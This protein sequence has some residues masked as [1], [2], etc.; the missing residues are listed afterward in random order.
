M[1]LHREKEHGAGVH[2]EEQ[3]SGVPGIA[4]KELP[5]RLAVSLAREPVRAKD[6]QNGR[7]SQK[8][9][10]SEGV[11][12]RSLRFHGVVIFEPRCSNPG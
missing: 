3:D 12:P 5:K 9:K 10:I 8:I 2:E 6:E 11:R 7:C 1:P 4:A